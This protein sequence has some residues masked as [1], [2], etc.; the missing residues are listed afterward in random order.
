MKNLK[1]PETTHHAA[2]YARRKFTDQVLPDEPDPTPV[3][4]IITMKTHLKDLPD[5]TIE[6]IYMDC[7]KMDSHHPRPQFQQLLLDIQDGKYTCIVMYSLVTF[8][9]DNAETEYYVLRQFASQ[10][11]RI[12]SVHDDYDSSIS[13]P[14]TGSY[15]RLEELLQPSL[16]SNHTCSQVFMEKTSDHKQWIF[17][18][19]KIPYGY[20]F[21]PDTES[22]MDIDP[23]AAQYV[24]YIFEEYAS[25]TSPGKIAKKLTDMNVP[26]PS[27]RKSQLGT[28]YKKMSPSNSWTFG[29]VSYILRNRMY[30][31]DYICGRENSFL[32]PDHK[33]TTSYWNSEEQIIPHHHE[34]LV[35]RATF[36]KVW[37]LQEQ[38]RRRLIE[39]EGNSHDMPEYS[40]TPFRN[41]LFCGHCGSIMHFYHSIHVRHHYT[42]YICSSRKKKMENAC[43]YAPIRLNEILPAVKQAL[44][45]E[46]GLAL[47]IYEQMKN[48]RD[49][50]IYQ[51][52]EKYF[53]KKIDTLRDAG[54]GNH[55]ELLA[56]KEKKTFH[57]A[58]K[59][60]NPWLMLYTH[61]DEHF[62]ITLDTARKYIYRIY[63]Y[64]DAP[65]EFQPM[66]QEAKSNLLGYFDLVKDTRT[67]S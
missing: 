35:P 44:A 45:D 51:R 60:T 24:R 43:S 10:G 4:Q 39:K 55:E 12:I 54:N 14:V 28:N 1:K 57:R 40:S 59:I 52:L 50:E 15:F 37:K 36:D 20:H 67:D 46:R 18:K 66:N 26:T 2:L 48:G 61:L 53:Q 33:D 25:G 64:A 30:S 31:G 27:M 65:L 42:A 7:Q 58:F 63:L 49:S 17:S 47:T 16:H 29:S 62:E 23:E 38:N 3:S 22:H 19:R 34:P 6:R 8:G 21:N 56:L 11:L 5:V 13:E 32:H 9:K 41:H